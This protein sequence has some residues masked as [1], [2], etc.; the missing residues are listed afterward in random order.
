MFGD[1]GVDLKA[2]P[3]GARR[4][5]MMASTPKLL[6]ALEKLLAAYEIPNA[7]MRRDDP[8]RKLW[9]AAREAVAEANGQP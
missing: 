9:L 6:R 4:A 1:G 3:N 2:V 8:R 7:R 5:C